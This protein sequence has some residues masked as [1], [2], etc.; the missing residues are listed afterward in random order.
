MEACSND[1][2]GTGAI[3]EGASL[4]DPDFVALEDLLNTSTEEDEFD[5]DSGSESEMSAT[6]DPDAPIIGLESASESET[7][8]SQS[9]YSEGHRKHKSGMRI[10]KK[11]T[12]KNRKKK[13]VRIFHLNLNCTLILRRVSDG[14][15][16]L[17]RFVSV[18]LPNACSNLIPCHSFS[19]L[20][21][22]S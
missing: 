16:R 11:T 22:M 4:G 1:D 2:L 13:E 20:S 7:D 17:W 6:E 10:T 12:S 14:V 9:T 15:E 18:F 8:K 5:Q 3:F 19:R 21:P